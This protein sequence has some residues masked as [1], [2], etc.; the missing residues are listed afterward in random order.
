M[1]VV[2][3]GGGGLI[4]ARLTD[5]LRRMGHDTIAASP[6]SGVNALTGEGLAKALAGAHVVVDVSNTRSSEETGALE[7]FV[8]LSMNV[9]SAGMDAGVSHYVMLSIVGVDRVRDSA[10]FL[11]K[12]A[13]EAAIKEYSIPYTIVRSTQ[14]FELVERLLE[15]NADRNIVRLP[16]A[17][18]Q[19][20]AADDVAEA[21]ADIAVN[22]ALNATVEVAGPE[23]FQ[24]ADVARLILSAHEDP[25]RVIMDPEARYFGA[26]LKGDSLILGPK[27]RIGSNSF[28]DWLRQ[29]MAAD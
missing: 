13:Q 12:E 2:V 14:F 3:I 22:S 4:G 28:G 27:P 7:F 5:A 25:R 19:P 23:I 26:A 8:K 9:L 24:F 15:T 29:F 6:S 1:R 17:L 10:Y 20:I 11:A 16:S 18:I 21:L